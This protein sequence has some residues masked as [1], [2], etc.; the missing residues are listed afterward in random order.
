MSDSIFVEV[1]GCTESGKTQ[2][3]EGTVK[4][5]DGLAI[6]VGPEK[7]EHGLIAMLRCVLA[8][9]RLSNEIGLTRY[10]IAAIA[11]ELLD[12]QFHDEKSISTV[13]HAC[14]LHEPVPSDGGQARFAA[15]FATPDRSEGTNTSLV[16]AEQTA[17][18]TCSPVD[19]PQQEDRGAV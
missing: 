8:A 2:P 1:Y 17:G 15:W 14:R 9:M 13:V 16:Q 18:H 5:G 7:D 11:N 19:P 3:V 12:D 6:F 4:V 10:N